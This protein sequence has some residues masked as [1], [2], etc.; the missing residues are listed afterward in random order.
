MN[1]GSSLKKIASIHYTRQLLQFINVMIKFTSSFNPRTD[2]RREKEK[3][4]RLFYDV[5][6]DECACVYKL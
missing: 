5:L 1:I 2:G 3:N 6:V 4:D